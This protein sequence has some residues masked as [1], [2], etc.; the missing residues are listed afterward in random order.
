[1][2]QAIL[3]RLMKYLFLALVLLSSCAFA[4][5]VTVLELWGSPSSYVV[6]N[7][8]LSLLPSDGYNFITTIGTHFFGDPAPD[9]IDIAVNAFPNVSLHWFYLDL[10]VPQGQM[11]Q[12]GFYPSAT[13]YPF[14]ASNVPGLSLY[15]DGRGDNQSIGYFNIL[16]ISYSGTL[17]QT[18][19]V[20]FVQYDELN[21]NAIS[22][23]SLRYNS[24]IP[25]A[26]VPESS[27]LLLWLGGFALILAGKMLVSYQSAL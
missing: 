26:S 11:L 3:D 7:Q 21:L 22:S 10:A 13:R 5:P 9:Y 20:D 1:L 17:L 25:P 6:G 14:E 15:G 4:G 18:L 19:A 2:A 12:P 24:S 16:E 27:S 23:G 8:T